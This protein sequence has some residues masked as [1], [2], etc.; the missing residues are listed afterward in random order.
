MHTRPVNCVA[1]SPTDESLFI[2]CGQVRYLKTV[3][4]WIFTKI[5]WLKTITINSTKLNLSL[6]MYLFSCV[7]QDGRVLLWDKRKPNKPAT[8]IG[9]GHILALSVVFSGI[10][11]YSCRFPATKYLLSH[12]STLSRSPLVPVFGMFL[13]CYC[14]NILVLHSSR[15]R[16][17]L[18]LY[19]FTQY[20]HL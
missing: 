4:M 5:N 1:C 7:C 18:K 19:C 14:K 2:S 20:Q 12:P 10:L 8:R 9:E 15:T 6:K 3:H 13:L 16:I 11:Q 17:V